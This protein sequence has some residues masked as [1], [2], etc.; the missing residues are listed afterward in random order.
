MNLLNCKFSHFPIHPGSLLQLLNKHLLD[1]R[2][3][4]VTENLG[5]LREGLFDKESAQD[6]PYPIINMV[7]A[8][9]PP[10]W[11]G[12]WILLR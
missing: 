4:L 10:L 7:N 1:I 8:N 2:H 11:D 12:I 5:F 3:N 6:P 9:S